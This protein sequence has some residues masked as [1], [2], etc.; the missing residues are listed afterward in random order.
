MSEPFLILFDCDGTLVDSQHMIVA[1]MTQAF[2]H[3]GCQSPSRNDILSIVGLSLFEAVERLKP[4]GSAEEIER[5]GLGYK[6]CYI[7]LRQEEAHKEPLFPGASELIHDLRE[8]P[9]ILL[10]I[11]TGKSHKGVEHLIARENFHSFFTTIQTADN[12][13]SKPHP[14]MILQAM[15]ETAI[16]PE[17][18][19]MIG[20]TSFDIE[21]AKAA[22]VKAIGVDWGYHPVA[23][24]HQ[25]GADDVATDFGQ[26]HKIIASYMG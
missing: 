5:I 8:H 19:I 4:G 10:G 6:E 24:L 20:D 16:A 18:T 22:Q 7:A 15:D 11:A 25:A 17:R 14:G 23:H 1:A 9:H 3:A 2:E 13:P 12:A 21:M 26:L